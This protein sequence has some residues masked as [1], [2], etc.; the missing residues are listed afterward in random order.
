MPVDSK[1]MALDVFTTLLH[2]PLSLSPALPLLPILTPVLPLL[3]ILTLLLPL[4]PIL[5]PV[6]NPILTLLL[7]LLLSL[8]CCCPPESPGIQNRENR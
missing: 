5:T 3:P 1:R 8:V 2:P 7:P 4:L 6:L